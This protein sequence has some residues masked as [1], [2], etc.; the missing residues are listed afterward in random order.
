M[1]AG[2]ARRLGLSL[3]LAAGSAS[4]A[5]Q[6]LAPRAYLITPVRSNSV[7]FAYSYN[8]GE[9][10]FEGTLPITDASA[11]LHVP[12]VAWYRSFGLFGRSANAL[13]TL[14]YG[15]G[16]FEG[17]FVGS[18]RDAPRSGL[19]DVQARF[20]VNLAGGP[21]MGLDEFRQWR[22]KTLVGLSLKVIAPTGQYDP[23]KLI[24][25]GSN[26]WSFKPELGLS[27]RRGRFIFDVYGGLWLYT[28]NPDF[29]GRNELVAGTHAQTQAPIFA[30]E[31]HVSYDVK[32]RLWFALD[33]NFWYGGRTSVDGVENPATLQRSSRVGASASFPVSRRN[34]VKVSYARGAFIRFGGDYD[35]Y[36]AAWLYSWVSRP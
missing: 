12:A 31:T 30:V 24:N 22:Q 29:F 35:V 11:R 26:R 19:F 21:A 9:L 36:S 3:L 27:H 4:A 5:G 2:P 14:P 32:P 25:L 1:T 23:T 13:A 10:L 17:K 34:S 20:T 15:H 28:E 33:G 6:D 18:Q 16:L 7:T 8:T